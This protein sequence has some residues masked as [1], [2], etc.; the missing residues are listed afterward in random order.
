MPSALP[1]SRAL[2]AATP[3]D[4]DRVVDLV[5]VAAIAVV[6]IGHW[7]LAVVTWDGD[8]LAGHN[9]LQVAPWTRWATWLLQVMPLFFVVGGVAN[10]ASWASA[11]RRAAGYPAWLHGRIDRLVRPVAALV[12][13]WSLGLL[14][15]AALGA[16]PAP[17]RTAARLVAM[18]LW[19]LAVYLA[20][21]AS[22]PAMVALHERFGVRATVGL[23]AAAGACDLLAG[24]GGIRAAGWANF[25]FV[26][27]FA[28]QLGFWWRD[29]RL[30]AARTGAAL[31]AAGFG[32][33]IVLTG[34][35]GYPLSMVGGPG[36]RSNTT[37][38][39]LALAALALAQTGLMV[40]ARRRLAAWA[41]RPRLWRSVVAASGMAM[42]VY[43]WHLTALC[44]ATLAFL[45]TGLLPQPDPASAAWW[46]L[47]PAWLLALV[48]LLVPLV[49]VG[50]RVEAAVRPARVS[51]TGRAATAQ[52]AFGALMVAAGLTA[53]AVGG[54]PVPGRP[55]LVPVL[56][57]LLPAAGV[58][59]VRETLLRELR[60][61]H[62]VG[63]GLR[64]SS[65]QGAA[66]ARRPQSSTA[67]SSA[68]ASGRMP[69]RSKA[70]AGT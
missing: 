43:L 22:T 55:L 46:L 31:A 34:P 8:G 53:L 62:P 10:S 26:W 37:P 52:A 54:F 12:V 32:A 24:P 3:D 14:A 69:A 9:L 20:V 66:S 63:G 21:V 67:S 1:D 59:L 41:A 49:A 35:L 61:R 40:L 17:L 4:R 47:R 11:R 36:E 39:T 57:L 16:D 27:L 65:V 45:A 29:G 70:P 68:R 28:H 23:V 6:V 18:P 58:L 15:A 30:A 42:T 60:P 5:R 33:M 44:L 7:L 2:A 48:A 64:V 13:P 51:R 38:P 19:F 25:A 50:S 56:G